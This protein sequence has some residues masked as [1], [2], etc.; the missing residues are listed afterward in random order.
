MC[1]VN[2]DTRTIAFATAAL[3]AICSLSSR[4]FMAIYFAH[5]TTFIDFRSLNLS[6]RQLAGDAAFDL[7]DDDDF[8][9]VRLR[10]TE[11]SEPVFAVPIPLVT[12]AAPDI[13]D[14]RFLSSPHYHRLDVYDGRV[15][16]GLSYFSR[17]IAPYLIVT[18]KVFDRN[19]FIRFY[20]PKDCNVPDTSY[21]R[22]A[23]TILKQASNLE[24]D[25]G[26]D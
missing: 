9:V 6:D 3:A 1:R 19:N 11:C 23:D 21:I 12:V 24:Q 10:L 13:A 18:R 17:I 7:V 14:Q 16:K 15:S 20:A 26:I 4:I 22:W 2:L 5:P 8:V 25:D